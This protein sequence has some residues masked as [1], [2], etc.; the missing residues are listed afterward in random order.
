[1][2]KGKQTTLLQTWGYEGNSQFSQKTKTSIE[3]AF[4][5]D[6]FDDAL[7]ANAEEEIKVS[8][9]DPVD[10]EDLPPIPDTQPRE[11]LPGFD[12]EAGRTW[13]Y[14]TNY[15]VRQYQFNIVKSCLF[16]NTLVSLP[17][18][19]GKTFIAAVVMYNFFRWYPQ[20]KIVFMAPT[21]PLVAQQIEAC[22]KIMGVPQE[23]TSEMTGNVSVKLR[24]KA[25]QQ[26]RVFFLTPQVMSNDLS[27]GLFPANNV[28]LLVVDEAHR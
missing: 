19:L 9:E 26:K 22:Y 24:T 18:G 15:P 16:D 4:K 14:P 5:N 28:K 25:W 8:H 27:R 7:L 21:K 12:L 13:I 23:E 3:D 1:M 10:F 2:S 6:D 20:A 17:T 11:D